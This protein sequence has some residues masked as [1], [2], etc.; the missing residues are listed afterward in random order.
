[1]NPLRARLFIFMA[2]SVLLVTVV[3]ICTNVKKK[4]NSFIGSWRIRGYTGETKSLTKSLRLEFPETKFSEE[5]SRMQHG[6]Q[7]KYSFLWQ[8]ELS[9]PGYQSLNCE[10]GTQKTGDVSA[11]LGDVHR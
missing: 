3:N 1:M 8:L 2:F 9:A 7:S 10:M 4:S 5:L 11:V 6:L